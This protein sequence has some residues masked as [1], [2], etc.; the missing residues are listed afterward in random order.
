MQL[1]RLFSTILLALSTS[2]LIY[3]GADISSLLL[4]EQ[5]G[6]TYTDVDGVPGK[7]EDI[8]R[9]H[10]M[11]AA[12]VRVWTTGTY[13]LTY[14]LEMGKVRWLAALAESR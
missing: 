6:V 8:V 11:N 5:A 12:R 13:N 2:A 9:L 3:R 14:A 10:G 4:V 7:F 1:S